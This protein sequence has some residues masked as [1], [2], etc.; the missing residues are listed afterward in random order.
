MILNHK[1]AI[2]FIVDNAAEIG[3]NRYTIT[4]LHGLLSDNLM[5]E[6]SA[7]GR[8]QSIPVDIGQSVYIP[9]V[10]PQL[11]SRYRATPAEFRVWKSRW[12]NS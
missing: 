7:S 4:N 12:D 9:L 1:A 10:I 6:P 5:D 3:F 2:E 11:I 8:L